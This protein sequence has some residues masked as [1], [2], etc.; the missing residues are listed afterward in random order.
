MKIKNP[1]FL[2]YKYFFHAILCSILVTAVFSIRWQNCL[3]FSGYMPL[4]LNTDQLDILARFLIWAK[5]PFSIPLGT[6]KGLTFPFESASIT[7]GPLPLF[8]LIFKGLSKIYPPLS[9]FNYF[10]FAELVL[11]FF[12]AFFTC[13]ILDLHNI[14]SIWMKLLGATLVGLSFP[15]LHRSSIYYGVTFLVVY[16]P[17]YTAFAYYY[18]HIYKYFN[19]KSILLMA[20]FIPVLAFFDYYVL[21]GIF[22]MFTVSLPFISLN[23][24]I[25]RNRTNRKRFYSYIISF[26]IGTALLFSTISLLGKQGDLTVPSQ[27]TLTHRDDV[28]WGYGG[29]YGGGFHV[30]DVFALII[31][32]QDYSEGIPDGRIGGPLGPSAYLTKLGF[33]LTAN[34]LQNG[35]YEGFTYIGT[36]TLV[37]LLFLI[38]VK[39]V[40]F[41]GNRRACIVKF[42]M[43]ILHKIYNFNFSMGWIL[44]IST[45]ALFV[46]SW[47]YIIHIG[48]V[49]FN[50][51]GTPTLFIAELWN[52]FLLARSLGRLAIPFMLF[53][54]FFGLIL[55]S[56]IVLNY[57]YNCNIVKKTMIIVA[58]V[59]L[60]LFHIF[61]IR[62]YLSE[63]KVVYG[64]EIIDVFE[65]EEGN[66]IRRVLK[67]KKGLIFA[68]ALRSSRKWIKTC[69]S[70]GFHS[71]IPISGVYSGIAIN[72][73]HRV[74]TIINRQNVKN[75]NIQEI[76]EL[77]G[78]VAFAATCE[79][80][81]EIVKKSDVPLKSF[82]FK[83][84]NVTILISNN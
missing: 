3:P 83:N 6:I 4:S 23:F 30:A 53:F 37:I 42:K 36:T 43:N 50:S 45:F 44:W 33:P 84:Q 72:K 57:M 18:I 70:L 54:T 46:F 48:G 19:I 34:D 24:L 76:I 26:M 1:F 41:F 14:K 55:F 10:V 15:L 65:K 40:S 47:G 82:I 58:I 78:D 25:R 77:Y 67:D 81:E 68:H 9:E 35:Q 8:A 62:G 60:T 79:I 16:I 56:R 75:G 29:G 13:R 20:I 27:T 17:L 64:N 51:I 2:R 69:Y 66:E 52:R 71:R 49:R 11:V 32:P 38:V 12:T 22:F 21:F 7:R 28:S 63:S 74:Q 59:F 61:E 5:E 39:S 73:N 80:A 31:P